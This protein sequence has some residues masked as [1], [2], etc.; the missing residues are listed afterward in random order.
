MKRFAAYRFPFMP[1]LL[2]LPALCFSASA[3]TTD[4]Y[5][6]VPFE[7][8]QPILDRMPFGAL[9]PGFGEAAP[10]APT[11]SE[12]QV[13]A[14]QQKL[15][16]Q[17]NMSC[18]NITPDGSTAIGFTDLSAKPP[19]N[20]F[21]RVGSSANGW[22]VVAADY[23][24]EWAQIQKDD[25][26]ITLQL[27]KGLIDAPPAPRETPGAPAAAAQSAPPA[28]TPPSAGLTFPQ[29]IGA[30]RRPSQAGQPP[31]PSFPATQMA[32][33]QK[34]REEIEKLRKEGGDIKSYMDRLRERKMQETADRAAAESAARE[35]LQEL[36]RKITQEELSKKEREMNL[37]LIEQGARHI[38]DIELTP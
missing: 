26:T 8:Y 35:K 11:Q 37:N 33:L 18:I 15:A 21:L 22:N 29:R 20:Y 27:G 17:V 16:K 1:G 30:V 28:A 36:A 23:D 2:A 19:V 5:T 25:I 24:E 13:Q 14:E 7:H 3:A 12:A 31:M 4:S 32:D 38:S 6:P 10:A 34:T 9:P